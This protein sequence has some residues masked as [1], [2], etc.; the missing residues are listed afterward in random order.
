M[1]V[2]QK[3]E[4]GA[5]QA[6]ERGR[7]PDDDRVAGELIAAEIKIRQTLRMLSGGSVDG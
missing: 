1:I 7:T 2:Y 3:T 4:K 5:Q 6:E